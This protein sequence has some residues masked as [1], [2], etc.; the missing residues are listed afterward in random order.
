MLVVGVLAQKGGVGKSQIATNLAVAFAQVGRNVGAL[1]CDPQ[2][3]LE[4]WSLR[5]N[6]ASP[7]VW[8]ATHSNLE[9]KLQQMDKEGADIVFVDTEGALTQGTLTVSKFS[10]YVV[11]PCQPSVADLESIADSV[12]TVSSRNKPYSIVLNRVPWLTKEG[13]EAAEFMRDADVPVAP[14]RLGERTAFRK[15][16]ISGKSVLEHEPQGLASLEIRALYAYICG[17]LKVPT[18]Q[19]IEEVA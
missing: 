7:V 19:E 13:D 3:T 6:E 2:A 17:E 18:G 10:D 5:R 14:C 12:E 4:K 9:R 8:T 16:M 1:D 15:A 11:I